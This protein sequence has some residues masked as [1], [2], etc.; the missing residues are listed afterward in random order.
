MRTPFAKR[1][2]VVCASGVLALATT[3]AA[4]R[5]DPPQT[6]PVFRAGATLVPVD[7]RVVDKSGKPVTD[8]TQADFAV[9]EDGVRQ[10]VHHYSTQALAAQP[11]PA[12]S[13]LLRRA[14]PPVAIAPQDHRVFLILI[15]RGNL[16]GPSNGVEGVLHLVRDR[17]LPQDRVAVLAWNRATDFTTDHARIVQVSSDSNASNLGSMS[18]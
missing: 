12:D 5:Q 8:L 14:G 3:S 18:N 1:L 17:L 2:G 6:R 16:T 11:A 10:E 13:R 7:V 15:G 9:F 4:I